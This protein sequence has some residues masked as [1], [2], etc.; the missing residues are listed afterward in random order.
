MFYRQ[1]CQLLSAGANHRSVGKICRRVCFPWQQPVFITSISIASLLLGI[2]QL[3]SL[4]PLELM[5][6]D[7][8][9]QL[10]ANLKPDPRLLVV[11]ITEADIQAQKEWPLSD[12]RIAKSIAKLQSYQPKVI[13]LDLYRDVPHPPGHPELL[14]QLQAPNIIVITKLKDS[15]SRDV[16]PPPGVPKERI[17]FND[18]VI[19]P[20]GVIR[21]NFM[22]ASIKKEKFYS[23]SLQV[24]LKYLKEQ[25]ITFKVNRNALLLGKISFPALDPDSGGYQNIDAQGYQV[26]LDYRSKNVARRV[27]ITQVLQG[28]LDKAWVKDKVVL[29]GTTA[30]SQKDIFF[31][32]YNAADRKKATMPGVLV[33]AHHVSQI[34]ATVLDGKPLIGFWPQWAEALWIW[35][36]SLVGGLLVWRIR[37]PLSLALGSGVALAALFGICLACF[38][39][40]VWVPFVVPALAL[41]TTGGSIGAY[42]LF[43]DAFYDNLTALP[44]RSLF[45]KQLQKSLANI[46]QWDNFLLAVIF[47]DLDRFQVVNDS[48]GLQFGDR[49]LVAIAQRLKESVRSIDTIARIGGD[50]FAIVLPAISDVDRAKLVADQIQKQLALPFYL[51]GQEIFTT[52]SLGIAFDRAGN[53]SQPEELLRDAH[54]A[55]YRAKALGKARYEVFSTGMRTQVVTRLQLETELHRAIASIEKQNNQEFLLYY[56]PILSLETGK[57][58]G[59]ETLLRWQTPE[60]KFIPPVEFIPVAEETGAIVPLGQ[61]VFQESCRQLQIWQQQFPTQPPL[62]L[63]VNLSNK[64]FSQPDLIQ[65]IEHILKVTG[66]EGHNL[67]LEITESMAMQD[68]ESTIDIILRLKALKLRFSIDDFGTGYSSLSYLHRLPVDT[69]KV[70]R[71]FVSRMEE[72]SENS[73]IVQ[74][75]IMLAHNLSMDVVAEGVETESQMTKLRTLQC[76]Y[77]QG[78]F[79]SKPVNSEA[80]TALLAASPEFAGIER[81]RDGRRCQL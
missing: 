15:D 35:G 17:G 28:Q 38:T 30:P 22:F 24:S 73:A 53:N 12:G 70:D 3:E 41:V 60:G 13:G 23:F 69:L 20:D 32:P 79:F 59:F 56:Q 81:W 43:H 80:A 65:Q 54:T 64:Q 76:E 37:Y 29:I 39:Q 72:T 58:A 42:K 11:E 7:R 34:L 77:G 19:D 57:I 71:S 40:G 46:H 49:L 2:R 55:M 52:V 6:F 16:P 10:K 61:W 31:T 9:L 14:Q 18:F 47:L 45:L 67:K 50:E 33:H 27:T 66:I 48:L 26:L 75:I 68:V 36:W 62:M 63:S 1:F 4:Q 51:N 5:E 8:A 25:N 74:T 44:N 78:Y 21:R